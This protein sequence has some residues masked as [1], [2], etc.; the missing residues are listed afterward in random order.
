[1]MKHAITL[2]F[3]PLI[4]LAAL[5]PWINPSNALKQPGNPIIIAQTSTTYTVEAP[6]IVPLVMGS[7]NIPIGFIKVWNN[8]E[9]LY[10]L[11]E[12][13]L[14][15]YPNY[16]IYQTHLY[17]SKS[18]PE[19][20][21]PGLWPYSNT[22]PTYVTSDLYKIPLADIDGGARVNDT[23]YLMA[24]T[25]IYEDNV[26]VGSAYGLY[27]KGF[28][29]YTIQEVPT[30]TP[31]LSIVKTGPIEAYPGGVYNY[32][33]T[34]SNSGSVVVNNTVVVDT[35]P[36]GVEF[37][38]ATPTP[39]EINGNTIK[40]NLGTMSVSGYVVISLLVMFSPDLS[41][42]TYLTNNATASGDNVTPVTASFT[43]KVIAGPSLSIEKN[44]PSISYPGSIIRYTLKVTNI[45]NETAYNVTVKD[46]INLTNVEYVSSTPAGSIT[47]N[48]VTWSLGS[49][50]AG[51]TVYIELVVRVRDTVSNGTIIKDQAEVAWY[52]N[53]GQLYGPITDGYSTTVLSNP[54]LRITKTGPLTALPG[55]VVEY[56]IT[57]F[58]AGG[59]A[60]YNVTVVD[61]L[62]PEV[63]F[64]NATPTPS[65]VLNSKLVF[66]KSQLGPG[67]YFTMIIRVNMTVT[68]STEYKDYE[69][70]VNAT[71]SDIE[72]RSYG[73][74]QDA[75]ITRVYSKPF[76]ALGKTGDS[77][78]YMNKSVS[79]TVSV[80]NTG[81][82]TAY[83][84]TVWDDLPYG[85]SFVS[86]NYTCLYNNET[87][88]ITWNIGQLGPGET[89]TILIEAQVYG[90]EYDG[91]LVQNNVYANWTDENGSTYGPVT[92]FH[93]LKLY[94]NPYVEVDKIAPLQSEPGKQLVFNITLLNP[95][96]TMI[97][98]VTLVDYLP[99]RVTYV[100][101]T[102]GGVYD[103]T[104]HTIT[105]SNLSIEPKGTTVIQ[106]TVSVDPALPNGSIIL[107]EVTAY[108]ANGSATDTSATTIIIPVTP[109][110]PIT[111]PEITPTTTPTATPTTPTTTRTF[112]PITFTKPPP[113]GGEVVY[114]YTPLVRLLTI[115]LAVVA[116]LVVISILKRS[117]LS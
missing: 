59:S 15:S 40:W 82:S 103:N 60:A 10:V 19:W 13:D 83:N 109:T 58:N 70:T 66:K 49:L 75:L 47:G 3:I 112:P 113:V 76:I 54:S 62:P 5:T 94:V 8:E 86:S 95:T 88:R 116:I 38:N 30:P 68:V 107:N 56:N 50:S 44:G 46:Y 104:T 33:I 20:S 9:Y 28:F 39:S 79:F 7:T 14:D 80:T 26:Q 67:E 41:P 71:W 84:V 32:V 81:G 114:D 6:Y 97:S 110:T 22:Y 90:V 29:T 117:R 87:R 17:V 18:Q 57:V 53:T 93:P 52:D 108:W 1:M 78:G 101:S 89:I 100:S 4:I 27:F 115:V 24:H 92:D 51:A 48:L 74:I 105:W 65:E 111:T 91:V 36:S 31:S 85:I 63:T 72:G 45:G 34:I 23:I 21:A 102:H 2:L 64:I 98:S 43:T 12:I 35:L 61:Q 42:G 77:V 69:N 25:T 55:E 73:P 16:R 106:V 37:I 11:F 99:S 96:E